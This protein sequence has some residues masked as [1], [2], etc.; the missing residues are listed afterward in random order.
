VKNKLKQKGMAQAVEHLAL[1]PVPSTEKEK[2]LSICF[3]SPLCLE[4]RHCAVHRGLP[5]PSK[6]SNLLKKLIANLLPKSL[7]DIFFK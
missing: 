5:F 7:L 3:H 6:M 2:S 4:P 1:H